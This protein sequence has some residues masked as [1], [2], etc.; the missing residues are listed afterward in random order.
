MIREEN[1]LS[2]KK[3][4]PFKELVLYWY[5]RLTDF[6]QIQFESSKKYT[7]MI[8]ETSSLDVF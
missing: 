7:Q 8:Q 1:P 6:S 2:S 3:I 4:L 5:K